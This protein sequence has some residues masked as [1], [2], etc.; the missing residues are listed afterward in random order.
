M[1]QTVTKFAVVDVRQTIVLLFK[2]LLV[3]LE[4][5]DAHVIPEL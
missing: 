3:K 4:R 5:T 2:D 1:G